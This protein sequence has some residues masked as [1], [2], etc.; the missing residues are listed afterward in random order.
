MLVSKH[1]NN[2]I[3]TNNK[4]MSNFKLLQRA[5]AI[6]NVTIHEPVLELIFEVD[7][8]VKLK[9]DNVSVKDIT[10]LTKTI[11]S[12]YDEDGNRIPNEIINMSKNKK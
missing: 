7:K 12:Y 8:L 1:F 4:L 11:T 5:L 9:D 3:L 10:D 2:Y 6:A